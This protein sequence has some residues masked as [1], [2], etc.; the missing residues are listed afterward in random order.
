M[1][2]ITDATSGTA[3]STKETVNSTSPHDQDDALIE[4]ATSWFVRIT[5]DGVT[6]EDRRAFSVWLEK[7]PAHRLAYSKAESLWDEL[8]GIPD[9]RPGANASAQQPNS[10]VVT[11]EHLPVRSRSQWRQLALAASLVVVTVLGLW[12]VGGIDGLRADYATTVGET[13]QVTLAD[14]SIVRLNTDTAL[15]VALSEACRCVELLRGEAFFTVAPDPQRPF[16]V[17]A[18]DGTAQALGT[19]FNV[20]DTGETVTV[21][22]AEGRVR[23]TK[24]GATT[25][26]PGSATLTAGSMAQYGKADEIETR[27]VDIAALTAWRKG[28]LVFTNRPLR[29]VVSELDRYRPGVTLFLDTAIAD[30]RFSGVFVLDDTDKALAAIEATLPVD[31]VRVTRFLTLLRARD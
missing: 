5:S 12:S 29:D 13:Q 1:P 14:G 21:A 3:R 16:R 20:R 26:G 25:D 30:E 17:M 8:G 24:T 2:D 22:V 19:A 18:G 27:K 15:A 11:H 31:V 23:V 4:A 9:P 28:R 7:D 10:Q 6:D